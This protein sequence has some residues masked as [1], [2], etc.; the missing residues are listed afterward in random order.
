MIY[1]SIKKMFQYG[2]EKDLI[3]TVDKNYIINK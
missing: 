1:S 2:V 3:D